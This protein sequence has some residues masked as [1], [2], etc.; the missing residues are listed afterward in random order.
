MS[1]KVGTTATAAAQSGYTARQ[2][3]NLFRA[4]KVRG[5]M[6]G[7]TLIVDL[8]SVP[9]KPKAAKPKAASR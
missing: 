9:P 6:Y 8:A 4:G 7:G 1:A 5:R 2:I 3:L